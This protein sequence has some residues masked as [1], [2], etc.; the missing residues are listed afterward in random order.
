MRCGAAQSST[1]VIIAP[2]WLTKA[3]SP[4]S[5]A[6]C[7]KLASSPIPGTMMPTQLGPMRRSRCGFAASNIFC[8]SARPRSPSSPKPAV[9]TTAALVPRAPSSDTSPGTVSGGVT[10]T[11]RSGASGRLA[12]SAKTGRPSS[13]R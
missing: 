10:I 9:I 1:A 7:E 12:T 4:A 8:C 6:R 13:S 11:A 3:R 2:D 5:G